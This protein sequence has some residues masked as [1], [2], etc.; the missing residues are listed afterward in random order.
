MKALVYGGPGH[1][2]WVDAAAGRPPPGGRPSASS[3]PGPVH[4]PIP[5]TASPEVF[6]VTDSPSIFAA[7]AGELRGGAARG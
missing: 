3:S 2:S 6:I 4:S 5:T 1:R 7:V